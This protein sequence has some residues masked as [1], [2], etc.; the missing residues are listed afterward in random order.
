VPSGWDLWYAFTGSRVRYYDYSIN[1]NGNILS[2]GDRPSDYST[3]V[4]KDRAVRFVLDQSNTTNPFFLLIAPKAPHTEG[5]NA[6][7]SSKYLQT[8]QE[9]RIPRTAASNEF[10]RRRMAPGSYEPWKRD[11]ESTYRAALQSLQSVDDLVEAVVNALQRAGKLHDTVIIYTS[12]NGFLFGDHMLI[13]KSEPYEG[14]IKVPLIMRGPGIPANE[15][16]RQ[17]VNNL[18]VSATI[19]DLARAAPGVALDGRSLA[20]LFSDADLPW[21]RAILFEGSVNR[22]Q[23]SGRRYVGL[24]TATRKYVKYASG[25]EKLFDLVIDPDELKNFARRPSYMDDLSALRSLH[26][27]L[28]SCAGATCWIPGS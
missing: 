24:R 11:L 3:D 18:D 21:R 5:S 23:N 14:S 12:D 27:K 26:K 13:G 1:E 28:T 2:F 9:A 22:F 19:L 20:A 15:T 10:A 17:L 8:L 6:I 7:P 25:K 4:L 16:R